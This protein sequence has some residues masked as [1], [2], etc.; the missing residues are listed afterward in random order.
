MTA[1]QHAVPSKF[2]EKLEAERLNTKRKG[3]KIYSRKKFRK[4]FVTRLRVPIM[5]I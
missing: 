1:T 2:E 5:K 4:G 3:K